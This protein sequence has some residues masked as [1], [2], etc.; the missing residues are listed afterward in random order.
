MHH[1]SRNNE[2]AFQTGK[3]RG[4]QTVKTPLTSNILFLGFYSLSIN[5]Y[6]IGIGL[7]TIVC[8][9]YLCFILFLKY[10]ELGSGTTLLSVR[11]VYMLLRL[12]SI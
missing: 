7:Y 9:E 12:M 6:Q 1:I 11:D 5:L 8:V 10:N 3:H 2:Y 4:N